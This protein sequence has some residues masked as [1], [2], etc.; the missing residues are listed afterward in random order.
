[1]TAHERKYHGGGGSG[2]IRMTIMGA[3]MIDKQ[4]EIK[5]AIRSEKN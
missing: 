3:A 2:D 4:D 5:V 1:M